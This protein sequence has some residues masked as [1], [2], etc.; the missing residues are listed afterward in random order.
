M[1]IVLPQCLNRTVIHLSKR[2]NIKMHQ[3]S[4]FRNI[5]YNS[6]CKHSYIP[7]KL[8]QCQI[9][10]HT[11]VR[12]IRIHIRRYH[13]RKSHE[14]IITYVGYYSVYSYKDNKTASWRSIYWYREYI[15]LMKPVP[16]T[17]SYL[18]ICECCYFHI[19]T[20]L[21]THV[22]WRYVTFLLIFVLH[23]LCSIITP[24]RADK[25]LGMFISYYNISLYMELLFSVDCWQSLIR[26]NTCS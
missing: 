4:A 2:F 15:S 20:I 18:Y 23:A 14:N 16:S 9:W 13:L 12:T 22:H 25:L 10:Y 21:K 11:I 7:L 24:F 1:I 5:R 3:V 19:A 6:H 17:R 26:N 8:I